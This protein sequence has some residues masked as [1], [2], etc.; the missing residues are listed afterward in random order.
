[1]GKNNIDG[2]VEALFQG[3]LTDVNS[4]LSGAKKGLFFLVL[5]MLK[6]SG[7]PF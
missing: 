2:S 7:S 4:L 5:K 6:V 3:E 1:M